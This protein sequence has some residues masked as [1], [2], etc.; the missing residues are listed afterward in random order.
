MV[1]VVAKNYVRAEEV[2]KFKEIAKQLETLT[3]Q[4][5]AGCILYRLYQDMNDPTVFVFIEEWQDMQMLNNHFEAA[6]FVELVPQLRALCSKQ[7]ETNLLTS[8]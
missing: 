4:N 7:G 3:N 2:A 8:D 6:H 1:T 5:D